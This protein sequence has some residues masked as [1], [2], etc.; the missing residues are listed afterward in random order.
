MSYDLEKK[1]YNL[2]KIEVNKL[3]EEKG[4][5]SEKAR[6]ALVLD[7]SGSMSGLYENG[8]VQ[9]VVSRVM[10][11][12]SKFDDDGTLDIFM[13]DHR[14]KRLPSIV[15]SEL[16]GFVR[17]EIIQKHPSSIYGGNHESPVMRDII[18]KYNKED[19]SQYPAFIIF[20]SD[21]GCETDNP[22]KSIDSMEK[23]IRESSNLPIF[24]QFIG[25]G[26][27]NYGILK[28]LDTLKGR[29]VDNANFFALDDLK[30]ISDTEL[31]QRL[32]QEYPLWL[33]EARKKGIVDNFDSGIM[34]F[35][36]SI[37]K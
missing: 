27:A 19:K 16:F 2:R 21:G 30:T 15:E 7:V 12:A 1:E 3:S 33:K 26:N 23:V 4:L 32:L 9:D 6:V 36:N 37:F 10:A 24:W 8:L 22:N 11:V 5:G 17:R 28:N 25:I 13:Y 34:G 29:I 18:K 35:I 14:F 31:Y 20:I